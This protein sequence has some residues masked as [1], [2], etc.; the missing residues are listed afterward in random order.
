V[1]T[2]QALVPRRCSVLDVRIAADVT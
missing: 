1:A 2:P